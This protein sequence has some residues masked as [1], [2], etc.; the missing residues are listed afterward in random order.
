MKK[1]KFYFSVKDFLNDNKNNTKNVFLLIAEYTNFNVKDLNDYKGESSGAIVPFVVYNNE[2][3][4]KGIIACFLEDNSSTALIE[5]LSIFDVDSSFFKNKE[6]FIVLLDGLSSNIS[7]F[8]DD[9]FE[10]IPENTCVIGA[11]AG[12][13]TFKNDPVIFTKGKIYSNAAIILSTSLKLHT[14]IANGWEHLEGPFLTTSS[15]KNVLKTLNFKKAFDVYKE[16]VEENSGMKFSDDNFFEI[17]K[18]YPLG[19]VNFNNQTIVRDPIYLDEN[20]DM[21]LVGDIPQNS[22]ISI[23]KG[24]KKS[25]INSCKINVQDLLNKTSNQKEQDILLFDCIARSIFLG[26]DFVEELNEIKSYMKEG[27][28][29]FG[30]LTFGEISSSSDKYINFYN[31]SCVLGVLC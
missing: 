17:A 22:T 1:G 21:V 9:L 16:T 24:E 6:S 25:L 12:K 18:S 26:D 11:G 28:T 14:N 4:N 20:N 2:F 3:F 7:K 13:L 29:L 30:A 19:I 31:K 5:D 27:T 15:H 8:L 10:N 23:L